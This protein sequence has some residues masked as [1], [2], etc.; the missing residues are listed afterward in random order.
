MINERTFADLIF[1][2]TLDDLNTF[3]KLS[4]VSKRF[5][6]VSKK[7]LI[8]KERINQDGTKEVWTELPSGQRHGLSRGWYTNG[9]LWRESNYNQ[10]QRHGLSQGWYKVT[11][12]SSETLCQ[13]AYKHNYHQGH[14]HGLAQ[15]WFT[16]GKSNYVNNYKF[17]KLIEN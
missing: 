2:H 14:L 3:Y 10:G 16:N 13:I 4:Q 1:P 9:Q 7:Y 11:D 17:D 8:K 12:Q 5:H 15:A 6:E